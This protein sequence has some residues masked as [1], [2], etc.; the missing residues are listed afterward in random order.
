MEMKEQ[1]L[2]VNSESNTVKLCQG[3][4]L[5]AMD[6]LPT[7]VTS[8]LFVEFNSGLQYKSSSKSLLESFRKLIWP[9]QFD[10]ILN[11]TPE[12]HSTLFIQLVKFQ[13]RDTL[14]Y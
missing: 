7:S 6:L 10:A 13:T 11:G 8:F 3:D 9:Y 2:K 4:Y 14:E 1:F 5:P 12:K